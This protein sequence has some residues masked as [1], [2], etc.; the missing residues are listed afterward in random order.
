[1]AD[2]FL[3][4]VVWLRHYPTQECLGYLFGVSDSTALRAVRRCLPCWRRRAGTRCACP[5]PAR[6]GA[7][8]CPPC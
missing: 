7:A 5:T 1:V 2:Q 4:A 3:L 6:A 8:T